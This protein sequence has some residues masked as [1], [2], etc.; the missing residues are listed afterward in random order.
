VKSFAY[1]YGTRGDY[2]PQTEQLLRDAGYSI[3]FNSLH[4]PICADQDPISLPR[5]K[6]EAGEGMWMFQLLCRGAMDA[7]RLLDQ[8]MWRLQRVR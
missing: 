8:T 2:N 7:W 3:A 1:P 5:V 4:G 6:V